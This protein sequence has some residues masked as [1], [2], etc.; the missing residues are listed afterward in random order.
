L[1]D[2]AIVLLPCKAE[3]LKPNN[4]DGI[5]F[6]HRLDHENLLV[7]EDI[8]YDFNPSYF[9]HLIASSPLLCHWLSS[10]ATNIFILSP[11]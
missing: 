10:H 2:S 6:R 4:D 3:K 11:L 8:R 5:R 7:I 1:E 9:S